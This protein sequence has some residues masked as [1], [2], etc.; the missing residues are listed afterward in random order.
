MYCQQFF[1]IENFQHLFEIEAQ[2]EKT[3]QLACEQVADSIQQQIK[4]AFQIVTAE[5]KKAD[6][7]TESVIQSDDN[8]YVTNA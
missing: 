7:K 1:K 4:V 8:K 2:L 3:R 6:K 5:M